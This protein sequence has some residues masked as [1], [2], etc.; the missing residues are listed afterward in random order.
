MISELIVVITV[1][2]SG[3]SDGHQTKEVELNDE[4]KGADTADIRS[5]VSAEG[6]ISGTDGGATEGAGV[7][8]GDSDDNLRV[9]S[10]DDS[11]SS[12]AP[13]ADSR[14]NG[15]V[16][17]EEV[18][19]V[20]SL[21]ATAYVATCEG[22]IGITYS[23]YDVRNTI[24]SPEGLRVVATDNSVIP[25]DTRMRI[26]LADGTTYEAIALDRGSAINGMELDLLVGSE[27]EAMTF[28]RQTVTA[29]ILK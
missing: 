22:C 10:S 18:A 1:A 12:G 24:Y 15:S 8:D 2:L 13:P 9:L 14:S 17:A 28:G 21:E 25:I 3:Q 7:N 16:D 29:E 23:G 5:D 20:L 6:K 26:T 4:D 27:E 19:Q 11:D